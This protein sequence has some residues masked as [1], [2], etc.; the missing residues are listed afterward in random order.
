MT[1]I[2]TPDVPLPAGTT[3][4]GDWDQWGHEF[5]LVW[6]DHRRVAATDISLSP[7]AAQ[8]PDGS[9]DT[10][11]AVAERAP[12]IFIDQ[13]ED[14]GTRRQCLQVSMEGARHLVAALIA[15]I[16]EVDRWASK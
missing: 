16:D 10:E 3:V 13:A 6:G 7:C 4:L 8:L 2:N 1:T 11:G 15:M 9:I 14:D 12:Q 5:R